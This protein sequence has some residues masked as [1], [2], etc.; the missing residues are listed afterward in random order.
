MTFNK[1]L[2]MKHYKAF[3]LIELLVVI[4]IIALLMSVLLPALN[5][6][7]QQARNILC[8]S[9]IRAQMQA[10]LA[11]VT[12]NNTFPVRLTFDP[13]FLGECDR[14]DSSQGRRGWFWAIAGN[15]LSYEDNKVLSCPVNEPKG[16]TLDDGMMRGVS[17]DIYYRVNVLGD[18]TVAKGATW[19]CTSNYSWTAGFEGNDK[20][21]IR[22]PPRDAT[23]MYNNILYFN[24]TTPWPSK[25]KMLSSKSEMV[26]HSI[27]RGANDMQEVNV[28]SYIQS[29][30]NGPW[31]E[32]LAAHKDVKTNPIGYGDMHV[33]S[34]RYQDSV[35]KRAFIY[36]P[37]ASSN[38][39]FY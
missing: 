11:Y 19:R 28:K 9:N 1:R 23:D 17:W 14:T 30:L 3:T 20:V 34:A 33:E 29:V 35:K 10:Q 13:I 2:I 36:N 22:K 31:P 39:H 26:F 16:T 4:S 27:F 32:L 8:K 21:S 37:S 25:V 5:K 18:Q 15:Y 24:K 38:A 12:A 6:A 7:R